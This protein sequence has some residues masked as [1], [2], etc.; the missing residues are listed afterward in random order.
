M[1]A[2]RIVDRLHNVTTATHLEPGH[3]ARL[4]EDTQTFI[5]PLTCRLG[6][7]GVAGFLASGPTGWA[8]A[9][10][11]GAHPADAAGGH[12]LNTRLSR[13][14]A[15]AGRP[16]RCGGIRRHAIHAGR[17]GE[18]GHRPGSGGR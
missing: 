5:T 11:R 8:A 3:M 2:V 15:Q 13:R 4:H 1:A 10:A 12:L 17:P 16:A 18:A 7:A 9:N 14:L 6:L